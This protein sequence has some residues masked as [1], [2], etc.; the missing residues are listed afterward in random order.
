MIAWTIPIILL[1]L[2]FIRKQD[3]FSNLNAQGLINKY[4]PEEIDHFA[5]FAFQGGVLRKWKMNI[6]YKNDAKASQSTSATNSIFKCVKELNSLVD[7]IK[8]VE[9]AY[10]NNV[11]IHFRNKMESK[12]GSTFR[13]I[14]TFKIPYPTI[15]GGVINILVKER[16]SEAIN[17]TVY[18]EFSHLLGFDHNLKIYQDSNWKYKSLFNGPT[19]TFVDSLDTIVEDFKE[20]SALDKAAIRIMY[21]ADVAIDPGMTKEKFYRKIEEARKKMIQ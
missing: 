11:T 3:W 4:S 19:K 14:S 5:N 17:S 21:D 20:F 16:K 2:L 18:H 13:K 8:I 12:V 15:K 10:N 6:I 1:T 9:D 7:E